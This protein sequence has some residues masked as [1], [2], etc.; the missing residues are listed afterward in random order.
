MSK[1]GWDEGRGGHTDNKLF[2]LRMLILRYAACLQAGGVNEGM[3][4]HQ[5][6]PAVPVVPPA[7]ERLPVRG[8][9]LSL[10]QVQ[11]QF[12]DLRAEV[13]AGTEAA[14]VDESS[15]AVAL[16]A[17]GRWGGGTG[18]VVLAAD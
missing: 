8:E 2:C 14:C 13:R 17:Q 7:Q 10:A 6:S 12:Q 15:A 3:E 16:G 18:G 1:T 5:P 9:G 4:R 11:E